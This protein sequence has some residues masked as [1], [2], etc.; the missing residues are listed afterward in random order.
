MNSYEFVQNSVLKF[1]HE[2]REKFLRKFVREFTHIRARI[3]DECYIF[4]ERK[5]ISIINIID[6]PV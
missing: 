2:I 5:S 3:H 6:L 4:K 1:M